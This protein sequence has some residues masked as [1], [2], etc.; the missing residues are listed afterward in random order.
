MM[1]L[2][3]HVESFMVIYHPTK[4]GYCKQCGSED[5]FLICLVILKAYAS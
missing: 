3:D 2:K 5:M 1:C 4:L